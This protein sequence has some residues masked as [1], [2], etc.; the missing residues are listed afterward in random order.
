VRGVD[1]N[2]KPPEVVNIPRAVWLRG[3]D[4]DDHLGITVTTVKDGDARARGKVF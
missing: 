3:L 4:F 2:T 1:R